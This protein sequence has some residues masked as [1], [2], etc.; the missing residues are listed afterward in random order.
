MQTESRLQ[1]QRPIRGI[2]FQRVSLRA[3]GI[4]AIRERLAVLTMTRARQRSEANPRHLEN[5]R[6]PED[7][8]DI[9]PVRGCIRFS[10][11]RLAQRIAA[12]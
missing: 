7:F 6:D 12:N 3:D 4:P 1:P 8:G 5:F 10:L 9:D 2:K 11:K